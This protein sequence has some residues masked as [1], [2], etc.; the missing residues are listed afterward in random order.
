M[1]KNLKSGNDPCLLFIRPAVR[2]GRRVVYF[3]VSG[4]TG[5][6]G[7]S[8]LLERREARTFFHMRATIPGLFP[9]DPDAVER[10]ERGQTA[11]PAALPTAKR[12][13]NFAQAGSGRQSLNTAARHFKVLS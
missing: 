1:R 6:C 10:F 12:H 13:L 8:Q 9:A 5:G 3:Q 4:S 2:S 7:G 11:I